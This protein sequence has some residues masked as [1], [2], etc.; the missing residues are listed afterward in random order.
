MKTGPLE[1]GPLFGFHISTTTYSYEVILFS[2]AKFHNFSGISILGKQMRKNV[3]IFQKCERG[4]FGGFR[5]E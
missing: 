1:S 3:N 4:R 5:V 2:Y